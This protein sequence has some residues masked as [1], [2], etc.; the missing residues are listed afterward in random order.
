MPPEELDKR[1]STDDIE[2][3]VRIVE[4]LKTLKGSDGIYIQMNG[5]NVSFTKNYN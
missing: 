3:I 5:Y 1:I 2:A 4:K